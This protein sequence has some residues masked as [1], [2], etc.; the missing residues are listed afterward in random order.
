MVKK[1]DFDKSMKTPFTVQIDN[2]YI[3]PTGENERLAHLLKRSR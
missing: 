3:K 1:E 2:I